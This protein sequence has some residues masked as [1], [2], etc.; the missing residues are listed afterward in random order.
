[1]SCSTRFLVTSH[2]AD[3]NAEELATLSDPLGLLAAA[4]TSQLKHLAGRRT[5]VRV[6]LA[7]RDLVLKLF[8]ES[9]P[10]HR[11]ARLLTGPAASRA[12]AGV[13][14]LQ[15]A[16]LPA[17]K[18]VAV[19]RTPFQNAQAA[20]CLVT[21][22]VEGTRADRLWEALRGR[23]RLRR[24]HAAGLY[25]QD[26]VAT[27]WIIA[28][29]RAY[30]PVLVDLDRVRRYR[31]VSWRRRRKNLIQLERTLGSRGSPLQRMLFLRRYRGSCSDGE[32]RRLADD[33]VEAARRKD[34]LVQRR[35]MRQP[36][37]SRTSR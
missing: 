32:L 26:V 18:V 12:A 10:R 8:D 33:I 31:R 29:G 20:S 9:A 28:A 23:E 24:I 7:G 3:L 14:H 21:R 16:G 27:N 13:A 37:R 35:R 30:D 1:M 2:A 6:R 34:L 17:P 11:L 25:P 19:L 4:G 36:S 15:G 22:F 5:V